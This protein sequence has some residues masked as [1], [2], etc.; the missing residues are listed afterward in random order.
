MGRPRLYTDD[1]R[2]AWKRAYMRLYWQR[3]EVKAKARAYYQQ[4]R[5]LQ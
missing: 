4:K 5:N 2:K 1:E 3:P